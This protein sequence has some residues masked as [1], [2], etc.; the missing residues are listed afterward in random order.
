MQLQH[1]VPLTR[2]RL[3]AAA[4]LLEGQNVTQL[5]LAAGGGGGGGG[6]AAAPAAGGA[7]E[8]KA[9]GKKAEAKKEEEP[10]EEEVSK[11]PLRSQSSY[12]VCAPF[13]GRSRHGLLAVRLKRFELENVGGIACRARSTSLNG[14]K[15]QSDNSCLFRLPRVIRI[16]PARCGINRTNA[17]ARE[18]HACTRSQMMH[19]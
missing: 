9:E 4:N 1:S 13:A 10:K 5:L 3:C 8:G 17:R 14:A 18:R 7:A 6:G 2:I 15:R 19:A 12:A 16:A 11:F